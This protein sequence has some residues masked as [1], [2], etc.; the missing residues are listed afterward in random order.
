MAPTNGL[1]Y[2]LPKKDPPQRG[3]L[4]AEECTNKGPPKNVLPLRALCKEP[5]KKASDGALHKGPLMP[6]P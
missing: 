4:F 3:P 6:E 1:L 5:P 2:V